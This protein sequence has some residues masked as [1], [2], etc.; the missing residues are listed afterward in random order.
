MKDF[1]ERYYQ[2]EASGHV[3]SMTPQAGRG[4]FGRIVKGT[5]QP[6]VQTLT[7]YV[8]QGAIKAGKN[9]LK[10]LDRGESFSESVS[11]GIEKAVKCKTRKRG[12][13]KNSNRKQTGHGVK[14]SKSKKKSL[15][16]TLF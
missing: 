10:N 14:K 2:A 8:K 12:K 4:F 7:P 6:L 5:M 16:E 13:K 3:H 11:K 9:I 1:Y 15:P